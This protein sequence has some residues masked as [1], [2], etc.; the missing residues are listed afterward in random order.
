MVLGVWRAWILV[1]QTW[2]IV[3]VAFG[4]RRYEILVGRKLEV[5]VLCASSVSRV[6]GQSVLLYTD[7][8]DEM[9]SA[10]TWQTFQDIIT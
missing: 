8:D 7:D 10:D 4:N 3:A 1:D 9:E 5:E 6:R 2:L